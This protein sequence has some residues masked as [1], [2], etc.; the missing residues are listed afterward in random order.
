MSSE[1]H[2]D[3]GLDFIEAYKRKIQ[4][5]Y[6]D[7]LK[8]WCQDNAK[9]YC[10][11]GEDGRAELEQHFQEYKDRL[12]SEEE[13][14]Q[15][16]KRKAEQEFHRLEDARRFLKT[17]PPR[18]RH[19]SLAQMRMTEPLEQIIKGASAVILGNNGLG[20][21]YLAYALAK[22]WIERGET[23]EVISAS[24]LLHQMKAQDDGIYTYIKRNYRHRIIHLLIDEIDKIFESKADHIFLNYLVNMRYEWML[25]TIILGNGNMSQ[26]Q[27]SIGNSIVDRLVKEGGVALDCSKA[28]RD[29]RIEQR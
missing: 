13:A 2:W 19:A 29:W 21:T 11:Q 12:A 24:E 1:L 25:Q 17:I 5:E 22:E 26:L 16:A 14:K 18:Y 3:T 4:N 20:K 7:S 8:L 23:V 27:K 6:D 28:D 9:K 10:E 15:E